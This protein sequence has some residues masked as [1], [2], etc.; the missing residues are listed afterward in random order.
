MSAQLSTL[1]TAAQQLVSHMPHAIW[2]ADQM[3]SYATGVTA[4]GHPALDAEL[5]NH[6]WPAA[7]LIELLLQQTG[8]GEMQLLRPALA[9]IAQQR[10]I[11]LVQ[12]PHAPH[13]AAWLGSGLPPER[14]LWIKTARSADALWS[15]EQVL[16]NGS[17]GAVLLWQTQVR[18]EA[19]R[20]LHLAAQGGDTV[21]WMFRPLTT[22]QDASPSPLRLGLR[23]ARA[24]IEIDLIKRRGPHA[25]QTLYLPL[26]AMP[27]APATIPPVRHA[28]LDQRASAAIS[29]RNLAPALV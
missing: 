7:T 10:R 27:S 24:G 17:C 8:I 11:V 6:G 25:A 13:I 3:G 15:A 4:S 22:A 23:P 16:R 29:T 20:R 2:R 5:P 1:S 12:P 28:L 18:S 9:T 26:A 21:F 14:L 19:L